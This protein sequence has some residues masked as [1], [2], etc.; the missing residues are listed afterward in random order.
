MASRMHRAAPGAGPLPAGADVHVAGSGPG[1][2]GSP[3]QLLLLQV[4]AALH[5]LIPHPPPTPRGCSALPPSRQPACGQSSRLSSSSS[6]SRGS[7]PPPRLAGQEG[8][9]EL[10]GCPLVLGRAQQPPPPMGLPTRPQTRPQ[11]G[12]SRWRQRRGLAGAGGGSSSS[13][14]WP[15]AAATSGTALMGAVALLLCHGQARS[16]GCSLGSWREMCRQLATHFPLRRT[17]GHRLLLPVRCGHSGCYH[18][19]NKMQD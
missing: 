7:P 13:S 4:R 15:P 2:P 17:L 6:G 11:H 3:E 12:G 10:A 1:A 5:V 16:P 19:R 14:R 18:P 8:C 9:L